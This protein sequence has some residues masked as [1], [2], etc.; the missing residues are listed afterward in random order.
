MKRWEERARKEVASAYGS[1]SLSMQDSLPGHLEQLV[2]ALSNCTVK[3]NVEIAKTTINSKDIGKEHGKDRADNS[4]YSMEEVILEYRLL[5]QTIL[6]VL[7]E[8]VVLSAVERD[9]ITDLIEQGVNDAASE[10]SRALK[11]HHEDFNATL[12]HDLRGPITAAKASA[13]LILRRSDKPEL[14]I[15]NAT[16]VIESLGRMDTMVQNLLDVDRIRAGLGLQLN[17]SECDPTALAREVVDGMIT[18][19][20]PRFSL[21]SDVE[22]RAHWSCDLIT[23][24]LENLMSN[25]VKYGN[26]RAEI[27]S[28]LKLSGN[29]IT[30]TVHNSGNPIKKEEIATLFEKHHRAEAAEGQVKGWGIGLTLV[31]GAMKAHYGSVHVE[32]SEKSGTSFIM[33]LPMDS[34]NKPQ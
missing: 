23:R 2:V 19:H 14:C 22:A 7:D 29:S 25:A 8:E 3:S 33:T 18:V 20:G 31:S 27:S 28:K 16:R 11:Q 5:R 15:K 1:T 30:M 4:K 9:I 34:R 17:L 26:S 13:Q 24:S 12:T 32:S 21:E 6:Q 10:F